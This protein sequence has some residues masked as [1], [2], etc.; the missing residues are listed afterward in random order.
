MLISWNWLNR[1]V[2]LSEL[3][4]RTVGEEFTLKVAELDAITEIGAGLEAMRTVRIEE[5]SPVEGA[6]KLTKVRVRD[7]KEDLELVCGAPNVRDAVGRIAVL[8]PEGSTLPNGLEIKRAV[9]RG[10]ESRGMLASEQELGLSEHHDGILLLGDE[11]EAG[12]SFPEAVPVHDWVFE[13][14]NKAITHRPDLWGH[15]G[16]AR[17]IAILTD[18]PLQ[19]LDPKPEYTREGRVLVDVAVPTLC[20]RYLCAYFSDVKIAPSPEWLQCLLRATGVQAISNVVDLT[21]FVMMDVGNPLHAFDARDVA[22]STITVR[23]A[24]EGETITTLDGQERACTSQDLLIC[25]ATQPIA[26]AGVMGGAN[27]EIRSDTGNVILEAANFDSGTIRR[28]SSR[29]GLRTDSSARFEKALDPEMAGLAARHF[30]QLML[31]VVGCSVAS[32]LSDTYEPPPTTAPIRLHP[33][34]VTERL[35]IKISI[36]VIRQTLMKLGF[37]VQDRSTGELLVEVPSWR[38]TGDIAITEDLIE[39]IGRLHGYTNIPPV[40]PAVSL[41]TPLL[42]PE[43]RQQRAA[44]TYLSSN[45]AMHEVL[46]YA[47][48]ARPILE[49]IG[50][51]TDGRLELANPISAEWDTM[52]LS[53]VPNL[54]KFAEDNARYFG[55]FALYEVGRTFHPVEGELPIQDR[56]VSF[57]TVNDPNEDAE[58]RY[59]ALRGTVDGLLQAIGATEIATERM[60]SD[61]F[62]WRS[63]W[64]HPNR[65][66]KLTIKGQEVG[67]LTLIHPRAQQALAVEAPVALAELNLS[68]L[69][70]HGVRSD[71]YAALP[72]FPSIGFDVSFEVNESVSSAAIEAAIRSGLD[73]EWLRECQLFANYHLGEGRKSVSFHMKFRADE[74]SLKDKEV[75]KRVQAMIKHVSSEVDA[76][77]RGG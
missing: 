23:L 30:T 31:D 12:Q 40:I 13:V 73:T 76:T 29:T 7:G 64:I 35:G 71:Q 52:R 28:T 51:P 27:S 77:L 22:Q 49:R 10:V 24:S 54:L 41:Q 44:R 4:P 60:T 2:D 19:R 16:I 3:D 70:Q 53:L 32:R 5:V 72:R 59:R 18:R 42:T 21:N 56:M 36:G 15:Y 66:A 45:R 37:K 48:T 75:H 8:C 65:S 9:I 74:R 62:G 14:D 68:R 34:T 61:D 38:A 46:S 69:L 50:A 39:E 67:Y 6:D 47:F 26:L 25:D 20:P 17:E 55:Q 63:A 58:T 1:H 33:D 43:K 57:V 11:I